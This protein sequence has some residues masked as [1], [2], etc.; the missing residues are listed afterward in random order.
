[1]VS[2]DSSG[3]SCDKTSYMWTFVTKPPLCEDCFPPKPDEGL[4]QDFGKQRAW[5]DIA[6]GIKKENVVDNLIQGRLKR[7]HRTGQA[8]P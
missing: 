3:G 5:E 6:Q 8:N 7:N 1:M 2:G 4:V